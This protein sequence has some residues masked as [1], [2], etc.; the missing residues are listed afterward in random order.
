M[1][2]MSL[3]SVWLLRTQFCWKNVIS[4]VVQVGCQSQR[5]MAHCR[6][7][8]QDELGHCEKN[9]WRTQSVLSPYPHAIYLFLPPSAFSEIVWL[10]TSNFLTFPFSV[11]VH[12]YWWQCSGGH[13]SAMV[14]LILT[15]SEHSGLQRAGGKGWSEGVRYKIWHHTLLYRIR[16]QCETILSHLKSSL[17]LC[18]LLHSSLCLFLPCCLVFLRIS[19]VS[20]LWTQQ[21]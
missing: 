16:G 6:F 21:H 14:K 7:Y 13:N 17:P 12:L 3:L 18:S 15:T 8:R 2:A 9:D 5:A 20:S 10:Q 4:R 19:S 1:Q 11:S